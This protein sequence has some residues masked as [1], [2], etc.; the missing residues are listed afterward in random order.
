[1]KD[2]Q[3]LI[4]MH[5]KAKKRGFNVDQ[6]NNLKRQVAEVEYDLRRLRDP[7]YVRHSPSSAS[8]IPNQFIDNAI[9]PPSSPSSSLSGNLL[10]NSLLNDPKKKITSILDAAAK[11]FKK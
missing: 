6:Y 4:T 8:T 11:K 7:L 1:M 5:K 2:R 9:L 10:N 3:Y